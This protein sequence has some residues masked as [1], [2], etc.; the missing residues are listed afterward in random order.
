MKNKI[1]Y[2]ITLLLFC[3]L[4]ISCQN[5]NQK[6][7]AKNG[8]FETPFRDYKEVFAFHNYKK[9]SDTVIETNPPTGDYRLLELEKDNKSLV[10]FYKVVDRNE[11]AEKFSYKV[12]DTLQVGK[13]QPQE[14]LS[15]G[16]C[17][18]LNAA[19]E[20]LIAVVKE[21]DSLYSKD[22]VRVWR[23]NLESELIEPVSDLENIRCI[24][25]LYKG[26]PEDSQ[27]V[28]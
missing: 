22:I 18:R 9:V 3:L 16:Y 8:L 28:Q 10:V 7:S 6:S 1:Q 2:A 5:S 25:E 11:G 17:D 4:S 13:L 15:I 26:Q 12:V 14:R 24:N 20:E 21:N 23:A 19:G 27:L